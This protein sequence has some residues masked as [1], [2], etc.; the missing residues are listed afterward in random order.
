MSCILL[1]LFKLLSIPAE[2]DSSRNF[3]GSVV[4]GLVFVTL[5]VS[6]LGTIKVMKNDHMK[7][8][9]KNENKLNKI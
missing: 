9:E 7:K 4:V 2:V 6:F 3:Y 5:I 8:I 1:I